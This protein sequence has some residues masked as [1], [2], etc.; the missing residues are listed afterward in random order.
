MSKQLRQ[1][2]P[3]DRQPQQ[4][5]R[6]TGSRNSSRDTCPAQPREALDKPKGGGDALADGQCAW[7]GNEVTTAGPPTGYMTLWK[8][9]T[10]ASGFVNR[11]HKFDFVGGTLNQPV[12]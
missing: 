2:K 4:L 10:R 11:V 5:S 6:V 7:G 8:H 3:R 9:R 12:G 1:A